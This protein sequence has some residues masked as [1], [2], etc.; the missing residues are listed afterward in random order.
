MNKN[1]FHP[2]QIFTS[3]SSL[4]LALT[5]ALTATGPAFADTPPSN[6]DFDS[7]FV[8][9]APPANLVMD[10]ATFNASTYN[11][12]DDPPAPVGCSGTPYLHSI[13]YSYVSPLSGQVHLD[14]Y[15]SNFDTVLAVW[16]GTR[17]NLTN[18]ACNDDDQPNP[19]TLSSLD[20]TATQ[21]VTYYIEVFQ[22][23]IA[24]PAKQS[25]P[26]GES[27][28][29]SDYMTL[30]L[31]LPGYA[32]PGKYDNKSSIFIYPT[33]WKL[34]SQSKAYLKTVH[35]T[36]GANP[37][38]V[39]FFGNQL[40][41][42]YTK[43]SSYGNM[44]VSIDGGAPATVIQKRS[45]TAYL[46]TWLSPQFTEGYHT[47]Q[48]M[49]ASGTV[50]ID[51][52]EF[53]ASQ[54][55]VPPDPITDL[56]A[57]SGATDGTVNLTWTAPGDDGNAGTAKSY[58]VRYST[59]QITLANWNS[60][61][62]VSGAPTPHF[63]GTFESMTVSGLV[64][65]ATYY[66]AVRALDDNYALANTSP[67]VSGVSNSPSATA[68]YG[69]IVATP[70]TYENTAPEWSYTGT[71][72]PTNFS[73]AS[74]GSYQLGSTVGSSALMVFNG[75][76]FDLYYCTSTAFGKLSVYVDGV[77]KGS[78]N[79]YNLTS[80]CGLKFSFTLSSGQH[81]IKFADLSKKVNID[82]IVIYP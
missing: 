11:G 12:V 2:R 34:V 54:D 32:G 40:R 28:L 39:Q 52:V 76:K 58:D 19:T 55:S 43:S 8:I 7:P 1:N 29:S 81:A 82:R 30:N 38:T 35:Q 49:R 21:G 33:G 17:G 62:S 72:T 70:G 25:G 67:N 50:N 71:W 36:S 14:T 44:S 69:G 56:N 64:P 75:G 16:T 15:G 53:F 23:S 31:T 20:F 45:T 78:I 46:Q 10:E 79:Q 18:V 68:Y 66:F 73:K 65:T 59:T 60:A 37:V 80:K 41:L 24:A 13:W 26:V 63:A 57:V 6:D 42:T 27:S 5:M 4:L 3:L 77:L 47:V 74:G 22:Y 61:K 9:S 48:F 51:A